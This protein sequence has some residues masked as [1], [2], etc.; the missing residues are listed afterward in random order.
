MVAVGLSPSGKRIAEFWNDDRLTLIDVDT[1]KVIETIE[2]VKLSDAWE[3]CYESGVHFI[4]DENLLYYCTGVDAYSVDLAL[5]RW[6][7]GK[8]PKARAVSGKELGVL[9]LIN[10]ATKVGAW[11]DGKRVRFQRAKR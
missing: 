4:D 9:P 7:V 5:V 11:A 8:K 1:N 10:T 3:S 6:R 2:T